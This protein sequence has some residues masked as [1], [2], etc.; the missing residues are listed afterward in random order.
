MANS[1]RNFPLLADYSRTLHQFDWLINANDSQSTLLYYPVKIQ[2]TGL[3]I[4][5]ILIN[6]P[7]YYRSEMFVI[8][9]S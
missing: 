7:G 1:A 6:T 3:E 4:F 2:L 9:K 8:R 5:L